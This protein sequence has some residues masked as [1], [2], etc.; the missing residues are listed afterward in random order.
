MYKK[1]VCREYL[2]IAGLRGKAAQ[3]ATALEGVWVACETVVLD[4]SQ[5]RAACS[6]IS[7]AHP[8][9]ELSQQNIGDYLQP[10]APD[11]TQRPVWPLTLQTSCLSEVLATQQAP[12]AT[13]RPAFWGLGAA[14]ARATMA[15]REMVNCILMIRCGIGIS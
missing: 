3:G 14:A 9:I 7:A 2:H 15:R 5:L 11:G 13:G 10:L 4:A 12:F 6:L 1:G 8:A